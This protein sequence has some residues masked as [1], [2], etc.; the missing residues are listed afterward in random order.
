MLSWRTPFWLFI[1]C[2]C[3]I[4]MTFFTVNYFPQ[5][6]VRSVRSSLLPYDK[7]D[8][9]EIIIRYPKT[10][11]EI[12]CIRQNGVWYVDDGYL[13]RA[14]SDRISLLFNAL[15]GDSIR[16]RITKRQRENRELELEDFG[17][18][19]YTTELIIKSK[20]DVV[21][22]KIGDN[23][24]YENTVFVQSSISSEI[25]IVEGVLRDIVPT[26]IDDI[27][28]RTLFP[29]STSLVTK[30][31]IVSG[32]E[33]SFVVEKDDLGSSWKMTSPVL[34]PASN[35][36]D[37]LLQSLSI[38]S[39]NSFIWHP[40]GNI[41][42]KKT[43]SDY[44]SPYGLNVEDATAIVRIWIDGEVEPIEIRIGRVLPNDSGLLYAYSN[45]DN[46]VFTLD[47]TTIAPFVM[48]FE[49]MR[50]HSIF[51]MTIN[52]ISSF[53]Y[54]NGSEI[55]LLASDE[56][57]EWEIS[58]PSKQPVAIGAVE[59]FISH[60][61]QV[62]DSGIVADSA[63]DFT[64]PSSNIELQFVDNSDR[65]STYVFYYD[66]ATNPTNVYLKTTI[67]SFITQVSPEALPQGLF[68][69][70]FAASFRSLEI[71]NFE[72]NGIEEF[73]IRK[74]EVSQRAYFA[75]SGE[76]RSHDNE[77]GE[78]STETVVSLI[79]KLSTLNAERVSKLFVTDVKSYG[80]GNPQVELLVVFNTDIVQ[81]YGMPTVILQLGNQ[82]PSGE[83]YL[84]I[85]GE[86]ELFVVSEDFGKTL[87]EAKL[88]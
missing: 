72:P 32:K 33:N 85:K 23:A 28:D 80:F 55:C 22:I 1:F 63:N 49:A 38:S 81:P 4:V 87:L 48:G 47:Q 59:N 53:S 76:W 71:F 35:S 30:L 5:G 27:R 29:Y 66:N 19:E 25:Y 37:T 20:N 68:D 2:L 34:A 58:I 74:G 26:S 11:N 65:V 39:I 31:E 15:V 7:V 24:P 9:N 42:S 51:T 36:V 67:S 50:N 82:L 60:L 57:G 73:T 40:V 12:K 10:N 84:R 77:S 79:E 52:N 41:V 69:K 6:D 18:E 54:K 43:I 61:N 13:V 8:A 17:L 21:S 64:L 3:A 14:N 56:M 44:I 70:D 62:S 46:S 16:E 86:E 45:I 78:I 83:Y 75:A 88:Y